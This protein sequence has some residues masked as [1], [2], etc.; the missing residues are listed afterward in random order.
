G[1]PANASAHCQGA[2]DHAGQ[3]LPPRKT[4]RPAPFNATKNCQGDGRG[5]AHYCGIPR[6]RTDPIGGTR[7]GRCSTQGVPPSREWTR[8][9][10]CSRLGF[11]EFGSTDRFE[12]SIFQI[13]PKHRL[14]WIENA[15]H[16]VNDQ[17]LVDIRRLWKRCVAAFPHHDSACRINEGEKSS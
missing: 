11:V 5:S 10:F 14:R 6:P 7:G 13:F 12:P 1:P 8:L 15:V 17:A 2:W 4:H 3:R 9:E 16:D